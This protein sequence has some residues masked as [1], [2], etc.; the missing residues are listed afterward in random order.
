MWEIDHK[1]LSVFEHLSIIEKETHLPF[2]ASISLPLVSELYIP[3][4]V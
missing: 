3:P 2:M 4:A 1:E